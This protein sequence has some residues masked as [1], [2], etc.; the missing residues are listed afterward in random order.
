MLKISILVKGV[1][2][3]TLN[4]ISKKMERQWHVYRVHNKVNNQLGDLECQC[5]FTIEQMIDLSKPL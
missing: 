2:C 3:T 1:R 4:S 5:I